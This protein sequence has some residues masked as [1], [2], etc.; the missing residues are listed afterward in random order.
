MGYSAFAVANYF[1][2]LAKKDGI[3]ITPL[4]IQKLV[5][6]AHGYHLALTRNKEHPDGI[7][8]V[9]DEAVEAW[10]FGPVF[11]SLYHEF[12]VFGRDPITRPAQD[13]K[14]HQIA[15]TVST[16]IVTPEVNK[17][18]A[19][20]CALLDRIWEIYRNFTGP[21]LSSLT[22]AARTPWHETY[23]EGETLRNTHI[24]NNIICS[25]YA[26]KLKHSGGDRD[27]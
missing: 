22:H 1:L 10:K 12:K 27:E 26:G 19:G 24:P 8:L 5:Y 14:F 16:D 15:G 21:Q 2:D 9:H 20:T 11:P 6:L 23:R 13:I 7:P 17:G 3:E 25:Y 4:K 18:D